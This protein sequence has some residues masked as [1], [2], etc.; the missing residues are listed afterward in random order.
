MA[1]ANATTS[2][3]PRD[4]LDAIDKI[5]LNLSYARSQLSAIHALLDGNLDPYVA[6]ADVLAHAAALFLKDVQEGA[7]ELWKAA[8][9]AKEAAQ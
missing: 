3:Q 4:A 5:N 6:D 8:K 1:D 7:D 2:N 9:N